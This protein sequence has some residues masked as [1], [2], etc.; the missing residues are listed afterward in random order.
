MLS[1]VICAGLSAAICASPLESHAKQEAE[2]E[3]AF[4]PHE[5]VTGLVVERIGRARQSISLQPS[6]SGPPKSSAVRSRPW[7]KVPNAPSN[8]TMRSWTTSRYVLPRI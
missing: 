8:T 7:M 4:S 2:V 1:A 3:V 5:D 6:S